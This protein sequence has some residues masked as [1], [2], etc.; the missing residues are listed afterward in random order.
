MIPVAGCSVH[1]I[2]RSR[3]LGRLN[4]AEEGVSLQLCGRA[5]LHALF[6]RIGLGCRPE[7]L[8]VAGYVI[9]PGSGVIWRISARST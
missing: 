4:R 7:V 5:W 2:S 3:E 1:G 9:A 6:P 8:T